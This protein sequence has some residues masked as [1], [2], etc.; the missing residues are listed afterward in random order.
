[1]LLSYRENPIDKMH[2]LLGHDIPIVMVSGDADTVV[3]PSC[4]IDMVN[5]VK[6]G[7]NPNV[8]LTIYPGVGHNAWDYAYDESLL[9]FLLGEEK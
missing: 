4:S 7:G 3:L 1:M 8:S 2:V 6:A 5:G 9:A